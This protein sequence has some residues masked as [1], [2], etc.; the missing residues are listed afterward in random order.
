MFLYIYVGT[1]QVVQWPRLH[2]PNAGGLGLIPVKEL[3]PT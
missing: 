2:A 3:D 1:S